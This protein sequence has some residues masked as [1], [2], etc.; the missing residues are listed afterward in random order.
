[1]SDVGAKN[2]RIRQQAANQDEGSS[3]DNW[4]GLARRTPRKLYA[5]PL[6]VTRIRSR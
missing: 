3:Y 5:R 2:G 6:E 1:M 4:A